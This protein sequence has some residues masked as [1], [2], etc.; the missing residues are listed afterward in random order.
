MDS[1]YSYE[2]SK[3]LPEIPNDSD[4][5]PLHRPGLLSVYF[6]SLKYVQEN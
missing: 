1:P 4:L 5:I 6:L 3:V 2:L